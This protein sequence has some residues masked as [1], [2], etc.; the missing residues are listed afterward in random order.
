[1]EEKDKKRC[2]N[3]LNVR[4]DPEKLQ[5]LL[6][7]YKKEDPDIL[8]KYSE[9]Y[10]EEIQNMKRERIHLDALNKRMS[11]MEQAINKK[12]EYNLDLPAFDQLNPQEEKWLIPGYIPKGSV[13][14]L[15]GTGGH[16]KTTVWCALAAAISSGKTPFILNGTDK[17]TDQD[18]QSQQV[19][20]FS[21]EDNAEGILLKRLRQNGADLHNIHGIGVDSEDL[22]DVSFGSEY[23]GLLLDKFRPALC[24]FDPIQSF[25]DIRIKMSE[26][27]A[28]RQS[29]QQLLPYGKKCGTT[30]LLVVHT[31]KR[32]RAY[33]RDRMA[34]SSDI[35]DL[36]RSAIFVG[37]TQKEGLLYLSHEKCS[38][39]RKMDTVLFTKENDIVDF[40]GR[41]P[42]KDMDFVQE[43][44]KA[45]GK[46]YATPSLEFAQESIIEYLNSSDNKEC[47]VD[48]LDRVM[49][50]QG[51][52]QKTLER[53][54]SDL[55]KSGEIRYHN[56]GFG[57]N[58]I[59]YCSLATPAA[60]DNE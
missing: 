24:I 46:G 16:G 47:K 51:I 44:L 43:K 28:M 48:E 10:S 37:E 27:N 4:S 49:K 39:G 1:M 12:K 26:R 17:E 5:T 38:Y 7:E 6:A 56:T 54:K 36:A 34:D 53:A 45:I 14:I 40:K 55:K 32:E 50:E 42:K 20:I 57:K 21:G 35:W 8:D 23:L 33:G 18:I 59:F 58:K 19:L 52:S 25:L 29:V 30:F 22:K 11:D 60:D 2:E 41:T 9:W 15:V 31:N 13:S 3:L